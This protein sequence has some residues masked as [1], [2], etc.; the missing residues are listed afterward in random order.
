MRIKNSDQEKTKPATRCSVAGLG[1]CFFNLKRSNQ[2]LIFTLT[3][4]VQVGLDFSLYSDPRFG[5][6]KHAQHVA[7]TGF[8]AKQLVSKYQRFA[9]RIPAQKFTQQVCRDADDDD[10]LACALAA[11]ASMIITGDKDLL[12]LHPWRS[13]QI[14][15]PANALLFLGY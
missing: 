9:K 15:N 1:K 6:P 10:V 14:L 2:E 3:P 8:T 11:N 13:V 4:V 12:V 5:R 7:R